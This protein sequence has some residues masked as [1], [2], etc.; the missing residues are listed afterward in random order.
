MKRHSRYGFTIIEIVVVIGIIAILIG[1]LL[2]AVQKVREAAYRATCQNNLLQIGLALNHYHDVHHSFPTGYFSNL[3]ANKKEVGPGWGWAAYLLPHVDE[4]PLVS[5]IHFGD[6]IEAASNTEARKYSVEGF[7]CLADPG[8]NLT[9]AATTFLPAGQL[10]DI[11][12][13]VAASHYVGVNG[14]TEPGID[15]D[16]VFFRNSKISLRD[17]KDGAASTFLVGE[18]ES[19]IGPATWVGVVAGSNVGALQP[20]LPPK[21]GSS[22]VL[23]QVKHAPNSHDCEV[24]EFGSNHARGGAHFVFADAHVAFIRM[25]INPSVYR[26]LATRAGGEAVE[27]ED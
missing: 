16:G 5:L 20:G 12:K 19:R 17:I 24:N 22:I 9:I 2:P 6:P 11:V 8:F 10:Q 23:G 27:A 3:D 26:A 4:A 18:R 14:T 25:T 7:R 1:L 21:D 15:G 13:E